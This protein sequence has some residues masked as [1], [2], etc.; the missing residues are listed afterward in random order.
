MSI[1]VWV[2]LGVDELDSVLCSHRAIHNDIELL[3]DILLVDAKDLNL[4]GSVVVSGSVG[5]FE[6]DRDGEVIRTCVLIHK[7][8]DLV[9]LIFS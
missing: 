5:L 6:L 7:T 4:L 3:I 2:I 8:F 1:A 9:E